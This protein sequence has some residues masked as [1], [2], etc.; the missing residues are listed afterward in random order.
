MAPFRC[1]AGHRVELTFEGDGFRLPCPT[2]GVE[3]YKFR[4]GE[5]EEPVS[6]AEPA[7]QHLAWDKLV[8]RSRHGLIVIGGLALVTVIAYLTLHQAVPVPA[9]ISRGPVIPVGATAHPTPAD[10][11][12]ASITHFSAAPTGSGAV[13][14]S[15]RLTN[16]GGRSNDYPGLAVHWHGAPDADR[17]IG[18]DSYAHP[19]LPFTA[20]NVTLELARPQGATGIDVTIS[21]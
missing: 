6:P 8:H 13:T 12:A 1:S 7:D 5:S 16:A 14:V 2:C 21:Y 20:A 18:R 9:G 19:P 15:F 3:V 4:D 11:A 10:G 17:L